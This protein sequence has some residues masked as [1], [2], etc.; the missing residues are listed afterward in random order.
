[1]GRLAVL[2]TYLKVMKKCSGAAA[3][4]FAAY[5][6]GR[7]RDVEAPPHDDRSGDCEQ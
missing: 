4:G 6:G 2:G 5:A 3:A 1:L 7:V